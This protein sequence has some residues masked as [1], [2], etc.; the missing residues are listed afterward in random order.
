MS[1]ALLTWLIKSFAMKY[2]SQ[3]F[4]ALK[5]IQA[6]HLEGELSLYLHIINL[7]V[8]QKIELTDHL[9]PNAPI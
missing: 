3:L 1:I 9:K 8:G 5:T 7:F 4:P 6:S 2:P